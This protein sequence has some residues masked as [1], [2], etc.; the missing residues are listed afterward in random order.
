MVRL[1]VG[2]L[3]DRC[4]PFFVGGYENRYWNLARGLS[5][6]H[7]VR[8][9]T[10]F[11]GGDTWRD[12]VHFVRSSLPTPPQGSEASRSLGHSL[13][14]AL[15]LTRSPLNSWRPDVLVIEA[16]PYLQLLTGKPWLRDF[17][18]KI[19]LNL[20]EAWSGYAYL[21]GL[22]SLPS[23]VAIRYLIREGLELADL[24]VAISSATAASLR[25][26]FGYPDV[27]I[28]PMGVDPAIVEQTMNT[29]TPPPKLFDFVTVGRLVPI[30]RHSEFVAALARLKTAKGWSG[31]AAIIGTG[32]C[33]D[34]L[35]SRIS[36]L[37]LESNVSL[38]GDV[39][40]SAKFELLRRSKIFVLCS[41]RE[42]FSLATL[43]AMASGLPAVVARPQLDEVYGVGELV[44]GGRA[45]L[46]YPAGDSTRLAEILSTLLSD[47]RERETLARQAVSRAS[48]YSWN[49]VVARFEK[50]LLELVS[51]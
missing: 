3:V 28:V 9:Y 20:N 39:N 46:S 21:G 17:R 32:P 10:S 8:V 7:D 16:I 11:R 33:R 44:E 1:K 34:E 42:G 37:G 4:S 19:V 45:G 35:S 40:D 25:V 30:K 36:S 48:S 26:N 24:V 51:H 6:R 18:G 23:R 31:R 50:M 38:L 13:A 49:Q 41:E 2:F 27:T 47:P 14:F 15:K 22:L 12:R 29:S 5:G 43:E